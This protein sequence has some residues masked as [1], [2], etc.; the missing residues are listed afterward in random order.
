MKNCKHCN[1]ECSKF[2]LTNH[3]K[4]C[5]SNL[6]RKSRKGVDNPMYGKKGK[7][8]NQ[9]IK[10]K[11][12]GRKIEVSSETRN[13][14]SSSFKGKKLSEAHKKAISESMKKAV[15]NN[16]E[17]YSSS[18]VNGRIKKV[19]YKGIILDSKWEETFAIWLDENNITW[20]RPT[21]GF[22]YEWNGIRIYY[23]D[24]Y[25]PELDLYIEVKGYVRERDIAKWSSLNNLRVVK[26]KDISNIEKGIFKL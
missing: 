11:K 5:E 9:F 19:E 18:N 2:G 16:P 26:R 25:L 8:S 7:G 10:A 14:I 15:I 13:K 21:S 1:K 3:E 6:D 24:F 23:P 12:E 17:S 4:Y 22:E 20:E